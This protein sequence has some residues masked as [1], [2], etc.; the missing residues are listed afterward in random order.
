LFKFQR[1]R[2]SDPGHHFGGRPSC[3]FPTAVLEAFPSVYRTAPVQLPSS[4]FHA[5]HAD[6]DSLNVS[7]ALPPGGISDE[8]GRIVP[9]S[10]AF[11]IDTFVV[12][13]IPEAVHDSVAA[14]SE[15]MADRCS[16]WPNGTKKRAYE[17]SEDKPR[18]KMKPFYDCRKCGQPKR[19]HLCPFSFCPTGPR[20]T[21]E[22]LAALYLTAS[23][24]P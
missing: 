17:P 1:Q 22:S 9:P 2:V 23:Q 19:G 16:T 13:K 20:N 5:T 14:N 15:S 18:R 3:A 7:W 12:A 8:A 4:Q 6:T 11:I 21:H 24:S 10:H